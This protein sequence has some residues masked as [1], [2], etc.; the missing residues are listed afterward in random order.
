M[1]NLDL[2]LKKILLKAP[3]LKSYVDWLKFQPTLNVNTGATDGRIVYYNPENLSKRDELGQQFTLLHEILH[4]ALDHM[5]RRENRDNNG[6]N[7]ACDAVINQMI[8]NFG[9]PIPDGSI[10]CPEAINY[11]AEDYYDL[12]RSRDDYDEVMS[13]IVSQPEKEKIITTHNY[14]GSSSGINDDTKPKD[15]PKKEKDFKDKNEKIKQK[16]ED[17]F[18]NDIEKSFGTLMHTETHQQLFDVGEFTSFIAWEDLLRYKL[19][20]NKAD[21]DFF[22]GEFDENGVWNYPYQNQKENEAEVEIMIDSSYSVSE[23]LV[24]SFLREVKSIVGQAKIK[25]AC[26]NDKADEFVD[27]KDEFDIDNFVIT[28]KGGTDFEV[29]VKAFQSPTSTKIV[30]TDGY[31]ENPKSFCEAIWVVYSEKKIQPPGGFVYNIDPKEFVHGNGK[32]K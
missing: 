18:Y 30:F 4:V 27:I 23:D 5:E 2:Q 16:L 7:Y 29:A 9:I 11:N 26:F 14:W 6:F 28:S 1:F 15:I 31:A 25:I 19:Q 32:K 20:K 17:D 21:Y 8:K 3:L 12:I 10:N 22:N 13:S 24:K